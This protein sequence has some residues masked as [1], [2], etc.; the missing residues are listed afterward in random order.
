MEFYPDS[1]NNCVLVNYNFY[2][3]KVFCLIDNDKEATAAEAFLKA[4]EN[5]QG[6]TGVH[7]NLP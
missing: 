2:L 7:H 5:C 1:I 4:L 6:V 3:S